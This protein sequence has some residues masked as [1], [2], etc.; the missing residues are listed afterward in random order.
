MCNL[1]SNTENQAVRSGRALRNPIWPSPLPEAASEATDDTLSKRFRRA[2]GDLVKSEQIGTLGQWFWL[3][4]RTT[5][6]MSGH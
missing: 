4:S 3:D 1:N 5:L 2:I 6:D